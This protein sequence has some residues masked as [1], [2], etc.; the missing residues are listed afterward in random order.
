MA[1]SVL[2]SVAGGI[3]SGL[4]GSKG[5]SKAA[6][7]QAA[8]A[9]QA[10]ALT[11][12]LRNF[13]VATA[14]GTTGL[15]GA[16][17]RF[18]LSGQGQGLLN[19]LNQSRDTLFRQFRDFSRP[20]FAQR[21]FDSIDALESRREAQAFNNFESRLFN[22]SG[23]NTG[24]GRQI[25]D[26]QADIEDAR[27]RRAIGAELTASGLQG[28]LFN[29][30]LQAAQGLQ[31]FQ[32]SQL[33]QI[34]TTIQG[35]QSPLGINQQVAQAG[36]LGAGNTRARGT[37]DF[38]NNLGTGIG[39]GVSAGVSRIFNPPTAGNSFAGFSQQFSNPFSSLG[40]SRGF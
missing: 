13:P 34:G 16:P 32:G 2:G 14:L 8:A 31:N 28:D 3:T 22:Q 26:F 19:N 20:D 21:F 11:P 37:M 36:L 33:N 35:E 40:P 17:G 4:F 7:Q 10:L 25:A 24:S 27:Q 38:F 29:R 1:G 6:S 30:F 9:Q 23:V 12:Q 15:R 18:K 5:S 39:G